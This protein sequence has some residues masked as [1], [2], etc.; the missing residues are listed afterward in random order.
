MEQLRVD[1]ILLREKYKYNILATDKISRHYDK[2][3][4]TQDSG[5]FSDDILRH[6]CG[7]RFRQLEL[8]LI[9]EDQLEKN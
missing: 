5:V 7:T 6:I 8:S 2:F 4:M 1:Y 3:T 9:K